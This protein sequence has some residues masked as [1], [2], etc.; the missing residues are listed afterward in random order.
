M[1]SILYTLL[2][3]NY[4]ISADLKD[5][6]VKNFINVKEQCMKAACL[7]YQYRHIYFREIVL[8]SYFTEAICRTDLSMSF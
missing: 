3:T 2:C 7:P 1:T 8:F 6:F 5:S 4:S